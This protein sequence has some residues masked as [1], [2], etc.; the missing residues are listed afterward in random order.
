MNK[1]TDYVMFPARHQYDAAADAAAR[2]HTDIHCEDESLTQ[3]HFATDADINVLAERFGIKS[4]P[5]PKV[6]MN[7]SHFGDFRGAPD[8]REALEIM[9]EVDEQFYTL[10]PKLR[11]K[12]HN[13]PAEL[14]DF[15]HD[16]ENFDEGVKL[17]IF[18]APPPPNPPAPT[19]VEA[20]PPAKTAG[21]KKETTT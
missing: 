14:W 11:A 18:N 15:V 4:G 20:T 13:K 6:I 5:M 8:L 7:P 12:F 2:A 16:P 9:R 3:Q 10:S 1:H 17:G 21:E 19:H